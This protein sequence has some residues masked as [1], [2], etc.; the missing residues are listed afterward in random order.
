MPQA[1]LIEYN[2]KSGLAVS[3]MEDFGNH[4]I[5]CSRLFRTTR[6]NMFRSPFSLMVGC[7]G[8]SDSLFGSQ[9]HRVREATTGYCSRSSKDK[10]QSFGLPARCVNKKQP[11]WNV[12]MDQ[13]D[14]SWSM[15]WWKWS[16]KVLRPSTWTEESYN[17]ES[18]I[19]FESVDQPTIHLKGWD[20]HPN[21][22]RPFG[23]HVGRW[24][25]HAGPGHVMLS[26]GCGKNQTHPGE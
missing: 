2:A 9:F 25:S 10:W 7:M 18:T 4:L 5:H 22:L 8:E 26:F 23:F 3:I 6:I 14:Q 11:N 20:L 13:N 17:C 12:G 19:D 24:S 21:A 16:I 1:K 15:T